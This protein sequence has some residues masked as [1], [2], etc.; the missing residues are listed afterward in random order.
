MESEFTCRD[1]L[2]VLYSVT[3][4]A[5]L[6]IFAPVLDAPDLLQLH[7]SLDICASL[8]FSVVS[9]L[10]SSTSSIFWLDRNTLEKV[11]LHILNDPSQADDFRNK[12][13]Q[14]IKDEGWDL[15]LRVLAD[16]S[17]VVTAV[18]VCPSHVMA[19]IN[20]ETQNRP[21]TSIEGPLLSFSIL[22]FN[23][24]NPIYF[25]SRL[26]ISMSSRIGIQAF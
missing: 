21:R 2:T 19:F 8:P 9:Q 20:I 4:D 23:N 5:T 26:R 17:I 1:D 12:R 3:S 22:P 7:A 15:F 16:G 25:L 18:I 10:E 13:I 24:L 6:R 11:I 14:E